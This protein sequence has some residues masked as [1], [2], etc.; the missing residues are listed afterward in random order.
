MR[1]PLPAENVGVPAAPVTAIP[2]HGTIAPVDAVADPV[3]PAAGPLGHEASDPADFDPYDEPWLKQAL[4]TLAA[5][6]LAS[7][8]GSM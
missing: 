3:V 7:Q 6:D 4:E 1:N 8:G 5:R 2:I